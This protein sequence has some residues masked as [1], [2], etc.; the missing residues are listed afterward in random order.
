MAEDLAEIR[1]GRVERPARLAWA[2]GLT[3]SVPESLAT[4]LA[5]HVRCNT[6]CPGGIE[7]GQPEAFRDRYVSKTPL[8]RMST[9]DDLIGAVGF[10]ASDLSSYMTGQRLVV[11]GGLSIA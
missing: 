6:I 2:E 1:V 7:R 8:G 10:L 3:V 9:E 11:D 4:T 5:P